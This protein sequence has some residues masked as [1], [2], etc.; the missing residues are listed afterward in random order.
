MYFAL[1]SDTL[2]LELISYNYDKTCSLIL[3]KLEE[4]EVVPTIHMFKLNRFPVALVCAG[5]RRKISS[6]QFPGAARESFPAGS[7][8]HTAREW[9]GGWS[10]DTSLSSTPSLSHLYGQQSPWTQDTSPD[11]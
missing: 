9:W 8:M 2:M 7:G 6:E 10:Q 4:N 1:Y 11:S 5:E 3:G